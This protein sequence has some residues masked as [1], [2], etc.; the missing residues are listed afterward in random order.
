MRIGT[1]L[2]TCEHGGNRVPRRYAA[3]F[4]S[5]RAQRALESHRGYDIGA[6]GVART[7]ARLLHAP[8]HF[9]TVSRLFVEL[10]RSRG[11]RALF[12]EFSAC[13][14][15]EARAAVVERYYMPHRARVSDAISSARSTGA[16]VC[17][18]GVHSFTPALRGVRRS[19]DVGLLYDPGRREEARFCAAWQA[20][21]TALYPDLRVR[22]NYPYLGT[23]DAFTT[24][25]RTLFA[26]D[27]YLGIELEV[28]QALARERMGLRRV[29]QAVAQSLGAALQTEL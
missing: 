13:L 23:S 3:L 27:E 18:I 25:L 6:L 4:A 11:H 15:H 17:H 21:L 5:R 22:R 20:E 26:A 14:D 7:L 2:L 12:S 8:L 28:N 10:N 16:L 19:A 1:L 9:A 24:E 29:T